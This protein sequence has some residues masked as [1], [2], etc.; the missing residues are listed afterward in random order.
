MHDQNMQW[1]YDSMWNTQLDECHLHEIILMTT[2][3]HYPAVA[4]ETPTENQITQWV[5]TQHYFV[6]LNGVFWGYTPVKQCLTAEFNIS[7][8]L[9]KILNIVIPIDMRF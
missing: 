1:N 9:C 7:R 8:V 6:S 2:V 3:N 5:N 4:V